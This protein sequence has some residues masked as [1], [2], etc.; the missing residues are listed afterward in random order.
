[1]QLRDVLR[2]LRVVQSTAWGGPSPSLDQDLCSLEF[3]HTSNRLEDATGADDVH[4]TDRVRIR[5]DTLICAARRLDHLWL[6]AGQ[7]GHS[8][9]RMAMSLFTVRTYSA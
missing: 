5:R 3:R 1:M 7:P 2:K 4:G 9:L 6:D 8:L